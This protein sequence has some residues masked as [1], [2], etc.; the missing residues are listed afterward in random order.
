MQLIRVNRTPTQGSSIRGTIQLIGEPHSV[1]LSEDD[2]V[3]M[4]NAEFFST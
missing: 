2:L 3:K 1:D 4:E